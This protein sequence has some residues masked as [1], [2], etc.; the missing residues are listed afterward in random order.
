MNVVENMTAS[1]AGRSGIA[2]IRNQFQARIAELEI[3]TQSEVVQAIRKGD[4]EAVG[5]A[6]GRLLEE[7]KKLKVAM[8]EAISAVRNRAG[9]TQAE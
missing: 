6:K 8:E 1:P 5:T 3:R 4:P 9:S 2:E 7:R